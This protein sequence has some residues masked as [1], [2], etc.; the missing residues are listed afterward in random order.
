MHVLEKAQKKETVLE[1]ENLKSVESPTDSVLKPKGRSADDGLGGPKEAFSW[2]KDGYSTRD[3]FKRGS[4]YKNDVL[5]WPL[6][7]LL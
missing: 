3:I 2:T 5:A 6:A 4:S 1:N 7:F